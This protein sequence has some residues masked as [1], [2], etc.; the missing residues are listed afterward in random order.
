[1]ILSIWGVALSSPRPAVYQFL[2]FPGT[3]KFTVA[4]ELVRQ[5]NVAG[6]TAKLLDNHLTA[7]LIFDLVP[8]SERLRA[9]QWSG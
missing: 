2:G 5:L 8:L 9:T 6:H 7:N 3:G 1:V 4:T